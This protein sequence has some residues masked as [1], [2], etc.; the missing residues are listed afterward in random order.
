MGKGLGKSSSNY[1]KSF[2]MFKDK[3]AIACPEVSKCGSCLSKA[4]DKLDLHS[5]CFFHGRNIFLGL[6]TMIIYL[7]PSN[8]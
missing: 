8:K 3:E 2:V 4:K 6:R 5:F 7:L 1:Y